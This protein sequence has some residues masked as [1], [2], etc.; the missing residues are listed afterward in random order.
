MEPQIPENEI[1]IDKYRKIT[2]T[3]PN[4]SLLSFLSLLF[5]FLLVYMLMV[6]PVFRQIVKQNILI[7]WRNTK[8]VKI[9]LR[10]H[11]QNLSIHSLFHKHVTQVAKDDGLE[12]QTHFIHGPLADVALAESEKL[13]DTVSELGFGVRN[14][15]CRSTR[16]PWW[17]RNGQWGR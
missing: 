8:S 13:A 15:A 10:H 3:S 16:C 6:T 2:I 17:R 1:K 5:L 12:P 4:H 14:T 7:K 11:R 9:F